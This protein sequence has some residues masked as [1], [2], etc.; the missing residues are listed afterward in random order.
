MP[1]SVDSLLKDQKLLAS[2]LVEIDAALER[3]QGAKNQLENA[4]Y[5]ADTYSTTSYESPK[6]ALALYLQ[7]AKIRLDVVLDAM[8]LRGSQAQLGTRWKAFEDISEGL[9]K[10]TFHP[11]VDWLESKPFDYLRTLVDSIHIFVT[12]SES[13]RDAEQVKLEQLLRD[14]SVLVKRRGIV[15]QSEADVQGVMHDYLSAYF[16]TYTSNVHV[17]GALKTFKPDG[18]VSSLKTAIEFKFAVNEQEVI[19]ALGGIFEDV[20]GYA[21]SDDWK[22]F[23]AVVYQAEPFVSESRFRAE[24]D[25]ASTKQWK[26]ILVNGK[27]QRKTGK[28]KQAGP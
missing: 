23:Y 5:E 27:G 14:T 26:V 15:P 24:L 10:T 18:G 20:S 6:D 4:I 22:V 11:S 7:E 9:G 21:G 12:P 3:A 1:T 17:H 8:D 25:R 19:T 16:P 2:A 28:T 13:L